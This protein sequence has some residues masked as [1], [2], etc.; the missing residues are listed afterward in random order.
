M[1]G[2]CALEGLRPVDTSL[3]AVSEM[4][5]PQRIA[6][7]VTARCSSDP[8]LDEFEMMSALAVLA[9]GN[10]AATLAM[11]DHSRI[12]TLMTSYALPLK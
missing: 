1:Q 2:L 9:P 3:E 7:E 4:R 6:I 11:L 10:K 5:V 12:R 8:P